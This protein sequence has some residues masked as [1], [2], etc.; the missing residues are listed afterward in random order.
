MEV[1]IGFVSNLMRQGILHIFLHILP[2]LS[3]ALI[4]GLIVAIFQ[5]VTSIQEQTLT[6]LPKF[7]TILIVIALLGGLMFQDLKAYTEGLFN[8]IPM[9]AA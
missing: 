1:T 2:V 4:I 7:I 3:A 8:L 5:A 9:L 6:F